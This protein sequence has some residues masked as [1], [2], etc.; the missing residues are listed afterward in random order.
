MLVGEG[1]A[2]LVLAS[3]MHVG[4]FT[5]GEHS[6]SCCLAYH[7]RSTHLAHPSPNL[8]LQLYN[9]AEQGHTVTDNRCAFPAVHSL[10]AAIA[11]NVSDVRT[12]RAFMQ[13][14]CQASCVAAARPCC[15]AQRAGPCNMTRS[16]ASMSTCMCAT[17]MIL[18]TDVLPISNDKQL[19][20]AAK[21]A[22]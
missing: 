21:L 6:L 19:L 22:T 13:P 12:P 15:H 5:Q 7:C 2:R 3:S 11:R 9:T 20:Q 17:A 4:S 1:L 16:P 8:T 14:P 10:A 18:L